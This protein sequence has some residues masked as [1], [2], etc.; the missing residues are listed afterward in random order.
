MRGLVLKSPPAAL[1]IHQ[2]GVQWKKDVVIYIILWAVLLYNTTPI[3]CTPLRL[4][5]PLMNAQSALM[6]SPQFCFSPDLTIPYFTFTIHYSL[7]NT[8]APLGVLAVALLVWAQLLGQH[9]LFFFR[10]KRLFMLFCFSLF[11]F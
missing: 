4:H 9:R 10:F 11:F 2:R 3:H 5:P 1:K 7:M 6:E 8:Q